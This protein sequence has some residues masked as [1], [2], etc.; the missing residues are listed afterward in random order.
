MKLGEFE[1]T[2]DGDLSYGR[3]SATA[4]PV[5]RLRDPYIAR[6]FIAALHAAHERGEVVVLE[7]GRESWASEYGKMAGIAEDHRRTIDS[8]RAE[9]RAVT[10]AKE[11]A[12]ARDRAIA[13]GEGWQESYNKIALECSDLRAKQEALAKENAE[14]RAARDLA[15][16]YDF[17]GAI[18]AAKRVMQGAPSD[19][20]TAAARRFARLIA[21]D[22]AK[23]GSIVTFRGT[24]SVPNWERPK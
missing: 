6:L 18:N 16:V 22:L 21:E 10:E 7:P 5:R 13:A 12:E 19:S 11:K 1:T 17:A 9:L 15:S 14:L 2:A 24:S 20:D 3:T 8:L 23:Q 4:E